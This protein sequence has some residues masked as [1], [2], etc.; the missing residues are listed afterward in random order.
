MLSVCSK[1]GSQWVSDRTGA[2]EF[3]FAARNLTEEIAKQQKLEKI[4]LFKKV[5]EPDFITAWELSQGMFKLEILSNAS[6]RLTLHIASFREYDCVFNVANRPSFES[7]LHSFFQDSQNAVDDPPWYALRNIVYANGKRNILR[8]T[9]EMSFKEIHIEA[10]PY[11]ENALSVH[12]DLLYS[13]N[14]IFAVHAL[15]AMVCF[16]PKIF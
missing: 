11:F 10:W 9:T 3:K 4:G 15:L 1:P 12:T 2:T 7:H 6:N 14:S 16:S 13:S 8:S 5:P